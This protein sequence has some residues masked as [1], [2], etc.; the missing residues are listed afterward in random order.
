[1]N[2]SRQMVADVSSAMGKP[3]KE[4]LPLHVGDMVRF[5][6]GHIHGT[7]KGKITRLFK[8]G[9]A[10]VLSKVR[11][12]DKVFHPPMDTM[13]RVTEGK[14]VPSNIAKDIAATAEGWRELGA[15]VSIDHGL[16]S[17]GI[18][19]DGDSVVFMQGDEAREILDEVPDNVGEEDYILWIMDSAG[20]MEGVGLADLEG[21]G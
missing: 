5:G 8:N 15:S 11:G 21:T 16:P 1:M 2:N 19:V 3:V 20:A 4:A 14:G 18:D 12:V 17:V 10:S 13:V 7:Y 9:K 6:G